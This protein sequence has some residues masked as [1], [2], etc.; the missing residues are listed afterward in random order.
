MIEFNPDRHEYTKN[1]ISFTSVT[2]LVKKFQNPF[3]KHFFAKYKAIQM[4]EPLL[5]S[6]YKQNYGW[7]E[8]V[9]LYELDNSQNTQYIAKYKEFLEEWEQKK[10]EAIKK[11][12]LIHRKKE[13]EIQNNRFF[14]FYDIQYKWKSK[15]VKNNNNEVVTEYIIYDNYYCVAGTVDLILKNNN[16]EII[17]IDHKTNEK[18]DKKN[19]FSKMKFP[20]NHLDDCSFNHYCLQLSLYAYILEIQGFITKKLYINHIKKNK[21]NYIEI[22]YLKQEAILMLECQEGLW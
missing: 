16:N 21:D 4:L 8:I 2:Q 22:P 13:Q 14:N 5:F 12:K 15:L 19:F 20:L 17:I 10:I 11:G 9:F 7:R 1:G 6:E 3:Q 18:I